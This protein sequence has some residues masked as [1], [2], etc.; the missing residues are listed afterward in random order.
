LLRQADEVD[1]HSGQEGRR[2]F[3]LLLTKKGLE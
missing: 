2:L 1:G 3:L